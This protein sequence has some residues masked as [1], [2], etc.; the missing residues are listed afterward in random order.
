MF[1]LVNF[2]TSSKIIFGGYMK[3]VQAILL[4]NEYLNNGKLVNTVIVSNEIGCSKRTA[5]RYINEIREFFKKYFP[6]KKIIYDRQSK[7]FIIQI[8]KKSQ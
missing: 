3:K 4:L 2:I 8:A 6:Y 7:S 5:L 1:F